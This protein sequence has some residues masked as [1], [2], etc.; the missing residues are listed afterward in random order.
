MPFLP[1][2]ISKNP[3]YGYSVFK[4][5]KPHCFTIIEVMYLQYQGDIRK[6]VAFLSLVP[7]LVICNLL[8]VYLF[9]AFLS[10]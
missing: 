5:A 10:S 1:T 9:L 8:P 7:K 3:L 6:G 4:W 2:H